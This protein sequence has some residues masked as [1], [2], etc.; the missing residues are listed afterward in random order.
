SWLQ[1]IDRFFA[2]Q[3]LPVPFPPP[4]GH[5][6]WPNR[7][8][9]QCSNAASYAAAS[10][11]NTHRARRCVPLIAY[12]WLNPFGELSLSPSVFSRRQLFLCRAS[13][14]RFSSAAACCAL[15]CIL[16]LGLLHTYANEYCSQL[17]IATA[18]RIVWRVLRHHAA[19]ARLKSALSANARQYS[20]EMRE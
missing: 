14:A 15:V 5:C 12:S 6:E 7:Q 13:M 9:I 1:S 8:S 2:C 19:L 17:M 3:A 16:S 18:A 11:I 10:A 20:K 4:R